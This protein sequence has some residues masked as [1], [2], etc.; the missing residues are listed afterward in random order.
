M[1]QEQLSN[2][3]EIAKLLFNNK[4]YLDCYNYL[5]DLDLESVEQELKQ[6]ITDICLKSKL[7]SMSSDNPILESSN[8]DENTRANILAQLDFEYL[9]LQDKIEYFKEHPTTIK[10]KNFN[11]YE[12]IDTRAKLDDRDIKQELLKEALP[13]VKSNSYNA[14]NILQQLENFKMTFNESCLFNSYKVKY[15]IMNHNFDYGKNAILEL[16]RLFN[17][18]G[19]DSSIDVRAIQVEFVSC[20]GKEGKIDRRFYEKIE[21]MCKN[22]VYEISLFIEYINIFDVPLQDVKKL[23][24][25]LKSRLYFIDQREI[26]RLDQMVASLNE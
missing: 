2:K 24:K 12:I 25:E 21:Q 1:T 22:T 13:A 7:L 11:R 16:Y 4:N 19:F 15:S 23:Y 9:P 10:I 17:E 26:A 18:Q 20:F 3:L 5:R 14:R 8:L 6:E